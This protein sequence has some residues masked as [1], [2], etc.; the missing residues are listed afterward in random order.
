MGTGFWVWLISGF[1]FGTQQ[2]PAP[3][4]PANATAT[5]VVE[6][7]VLAQDTGEPLRKASVILT[8]AGERGGPPGGVPLALLGQ[9]VRRGR[10]RP[11]VARTDETGRFRLENIEPG[12][13]RLV[14][15]RA[16]YVR[17]EYGQRSSNRPGTVLELRPGQQLRDLLF[18]LERAAVITGRVYD[19]E[20]EPMAGVQVQANRMVY[21]SGQ[22]Q[23]VP[24]SSSQTDDRGLYRIYGLS[25][26]RY[27]LSATPSAGRFG[28]FASPNETESYVPT[29]YPGTTDPARAIPLE[30]RAGD[31]LPGVDL[32]VEPVE[33]VRLRGV[34]VDAA[35]NNP[36][37]GAVVMV[38]AAE[39]L[40]RG[41]ATAR[42][43][44]TA[45][46]GSF[47][48]RNVPPGSYQ[49]VALAMTQGESRVARLPLVVGR[50]DVEGLSL[51]LSAGGT[52]H[53]RARVEG[54]EGASLEGVRLNLRAR[55]MPFAFTGGGSTRIGA[56][57]SFTIRILPGLTF[58]VT[59]AGLPAGYYLKSVQ[60]G[61][62]EVLDTGFDPAMAPAA[63]LE[64]VLSPNGGGV[65]GRVL[66]AELLPLAGVTVVL[67]PEPNRRHLLRLFQTT[68]TDSQGRYVLS[69]IA[70]GTYKLFAFDDL[71]PGIWQD[72]QF[73]LP[74]EALGT[75]VTIREN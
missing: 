5:C 27:F 16:G 25:P 28:L 61:S 1:L 42:R 72:P 13:Y 56:D 39:G 29:Y 64:I 60:Y 32:L 2:A 70:P 7:V 8:T 22:P 34:V 52:V 58:D 71:E 75:A 69:G 10:V 19:R 20:G 23:L 55:E 45:A 24:T 3:V 66:D 37:P 73:L 51:L 18:R 4:E 21:A 50:D 47:E 63:Q 38:L 59:V 62:Q 17:R 46:D 6:G 43:E 30:V 49:L 12:S 74:Y 40:V 65:E 57:G 41:L 54:Q 15:E 48:I 68:T 36:M 53:G 9:A 11:I 31:E 44:T 35:T 14:V 33:G 26:G 67:A